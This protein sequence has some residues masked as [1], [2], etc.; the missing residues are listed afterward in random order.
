MLF[1]SLIFLSFFLPLALGIYFLLPCRSYTLLLLSLA[2]YA[3]GEPVVVGLLILVILVNFAIGLFIDRNCEKKRGVWLVVGL[4]ANLLVLIVFKYSAFI[5]N[6]ANVVLS[7]GGFSSIPIPNLPL[8]LG[9]SFFTFQA[10]SYLVDIYR[11]DVRAEHN[12]IR[13]GVFKAFFPQLIAGPIVRYREIAGELKS[14][15][16]TVDDFA[17][18]MERFIVGLGK[19]LLVADPLSKA[20]DTIFATSPDLLSSPLAW[21]GILSFGLQIYFDFSGYSDMA[22]GLARMFGFHFPENFDLPYNSKCIQEFWRRWHMTLSRW[23]RDYLYIPLGGNRKGG[24]RTSL[25]LWVVFATTGFWHGASWTFLIWGMWHGALL[26]LERTG[27]GRLLGQMPNL[28]Q[29]FYM[30]IAVLLGWVWFRSPSYGHAIGYFKA[31]FAGGFEGGFA[32]IMRTYNPA[33]FFALAIGLFFSFS[34][35]SWVSMVIAYQ[36]K[37]V[38]ID[39]SKANIVQYIARSLILLIIATLAVSASAAN[40]LQSFLYFR[41]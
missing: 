1:S 38:R 30:L 6:N 32:P 13:M 7:A 36:P 23:F 21:I 9:V 29:R 11:G 41:F 18:G 2:F 25:N 16:V 39:P 20:V 24:F 28:V 19:K 26:T 10:I 15:K 34:S 40:T 27:F 31:L 8:P 14:R 4:V 12:L 17:L 33:L 37:N 5:I 22:I 35:A 3:W